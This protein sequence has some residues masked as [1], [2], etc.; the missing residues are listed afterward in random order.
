MESIPDL[1]ISEIL[2]DSY[3][4]FLKSIG[5][6]KVCCESITQDDYMFFKFYLYH[7]TVINKNQLI[8]NKFHTT[9]AVKTELQISLFLSINQVD[10]LK[11]PA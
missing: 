5:P 9:K 1:I 6:T 3:F 11:S 4:I 7:Q 10:N 8:A 2:S